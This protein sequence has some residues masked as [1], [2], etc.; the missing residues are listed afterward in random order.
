MENL[1][2]QKSGSR[3]PWKLEEIR[4]GFQDFFEK[5]GHYPTTPEIDTY[6]YLP[7]ARSIERSFGGAVQLRKTLGIDSQADFRTGAHSSARA[8]MINTRAHLVE[9]EVYVFLKEY[10]GKQFVH[11]EYFFLDDKRTRADFF[12]Y[13]SESGFCVDVF[14]PSD[15]RN[16]IGCLNSKLAKYV[17]HQMNQY[18][19]LFLQMNKE[20]TQELLDSVVANKTNKLL[21]GHQLF[22]WGSFTAFCSKRKPLEIKK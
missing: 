3:S 8:H 1:R 22:T 10:F 6:P 18:P 5:N 7:S 17:G 4:A 11:R 21:S 16:L 15:R 2:L 19:V 14:Y 20:L 12:V 9:E 13:D